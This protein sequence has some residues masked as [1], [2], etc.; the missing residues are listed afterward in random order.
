MLKAPVADSRI[1]EQTIETAARLLHE[2]APDSEVILFGSAARGNTD[3]ESDLDFL[4]VEAEIRE[5]IQ[6]MARLRLALEPL[7]GPRLLSADILVIGRDDFESWRNAPNTVFAE[8][9]R[10][11]RFYRPVD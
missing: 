1:D 3:S 4:V 5:P 7:L 8:A 9:V 10:D 2:A 6:E 11:G